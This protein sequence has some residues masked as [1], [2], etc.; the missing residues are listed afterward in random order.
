MLRHDDAEYSFASEDEK[1]QKVLGDKKVERVVLDDAATLAADLLILACGIRP[2][3]DVA[4]NSGVRE[5]PV[6]DTL[7][8]SIPSVCTPSVNA[9]NTPGAFMGSWLPSGNKLRFSVKC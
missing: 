4:L 2:R 8:D 9:R 1:M 3:I 6:N 5:I 7:A